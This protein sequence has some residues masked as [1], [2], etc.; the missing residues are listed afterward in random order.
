MPYSLLLKKSFALKNLGGLVSIPVSL[1]VSSDDTFFDTTH[2]PAGI[3]VNVGD[4][5]IGGEFDGELDGSS[6]PLSLHASSHCSGQKYETLFFFPLTLT[7]LSFFL[8]LF[9]VFF[10]K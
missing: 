2:T 1:S 3:G 7:F 4:T 9:L 5:L 8:H 10:F 6:D